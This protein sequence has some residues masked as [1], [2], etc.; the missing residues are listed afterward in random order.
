VR[1]KEALL[2]SAEQRADL[3]ICLDWLSAVF[4][5]WLSTAPMPRSKDK[6]LLQCRECGSRA[7]AIH[8]PTIRNGIVQCAECRAEVAPLEEFM[9][10]VEAHIERQEQ[11]RRKRLH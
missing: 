10:I 9:S 5:R 8:G 7:F 2:P 1:A 11:V 4:R 3:D 6:N